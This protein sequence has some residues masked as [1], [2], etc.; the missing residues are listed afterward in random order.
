M[1]MVASSRTSLELKA[2]VLASFRNDI[3]D[4]AMRPNLS[5][6]IWSQGPDAQLKDHS[7]GRRDGILMMQASTARKTFTE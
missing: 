7:G 4:H 1:V 5:S 6:A 2:E 3:A